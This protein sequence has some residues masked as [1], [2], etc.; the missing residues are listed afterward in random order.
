M[1]GVPNVL[2]THDEAGAPEAAGV[3]TW[4]DN[5]VESA[6]NTLQVLPLLVV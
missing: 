2:D 6:W 5:M 1:P 3:N 4:V